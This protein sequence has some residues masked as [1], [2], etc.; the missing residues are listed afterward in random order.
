MMATIGIKLVLALLFLI[1]F[2]PGER[3]VQA[4][5]NDEA[6]LQIIDQLQAVPPYN[7]QPVVEVERIFRLG[8]PLQQA[9]NALPRH[10][11]AVL[12]TAFYEHFAERS[13]AQGRSGR[14]DPLCA[15][16]KDFRL[17][18]DRFL[19]TTALPPAVHPDQLTF[20]RLEGFWVDYQLGNYLQD[21]P[22]LGP[23]EPVTLPTTL[24]PLLFLLTTEGNG[25]NRIDLPTQYG[26]LKRRF[27]R[28]YVAN[29]LVPGQH[30]RRT[31]P[32]FAGNLNR[33]T[34][35]L[36]VLR[37]IF[38]MLVVGPF[39]QMVNRR[40]YLEQA[41]APPLLAAQLSPD[42]NLGAVQ[43]GDGRGGDDG[44]GRGGGAQEWDDWDYGLGGEDLG[45]VNDPG[46]GLVFVDPEAARE[47]GAPPDILIPVSYHSYFDNFA[48]GG[49]GPRRAGG[50]LRAEEIIGGSDPPPPPPQPPQPRPNQ[51]AEV[52]IQRNVRGGGLQGANRGFPYLAFEG[53]RGGVGRQG[54]NCSFQYDCTEP[55]SLSLPNISP[56]F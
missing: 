52:V 27:L 25:E 16:L 10:Y 28:V 15:M 39:H 31:E 4:A 50:S 37:A 38:W 19:P 17:A 54:G 42:F 12:F 7:G 2:P 45:D 40:Q 33:P 46:F 32:F 23:L 34:L 53:F 14:G 41:G 55:L 56:Q 21:I 20:V 29:Y 26:E 3:E 8:G 24:Q 44:G 49:G 6:T 22:R 47:V 1:F 5:F 36:E 51:P 18:P 35:R 13:F 43:G 48:R 9:M 30:H 11:L